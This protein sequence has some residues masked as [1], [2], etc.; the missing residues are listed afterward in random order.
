[1]IAGLDLVKVVRAANMVMYC[2][3]EVVTSQVNDDYDCKNKR[4]KKYLEQVKNRVSKL[5]VKFAPIP[6]EENENADCLAK[7][8]LAEYMLIPSQVLSFV[9]ISP[10]INNI[11]IQEIGSVDY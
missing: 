5:Q 11:G 3:S 1:M 10:L 9:Q 7:A 2:N 4:M 8:T 6:R